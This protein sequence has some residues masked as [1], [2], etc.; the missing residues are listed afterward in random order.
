MKK[1][2]IIFSLTAIFAL[3][4]MTACETYDDYDTDRTSVVGFIK[5]TENINNIPEG[6]TKSTTLQLFVS[7]VSSSDRTFSIVT[8]PVDTLATGSDNYIFDSTVT[9]LANERT[10]SIEVTGVDNS[11]T[12]ER[13]FFRLI[14]EGSSD[15]VSGGR[16]LM[17]LRN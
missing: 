7:D 8:A 5:A 12:D 11:I 2:N 16:I 10:A 9:F 15:V 4:F 1:N 14:V 3:V 6:G 13:S 17:G